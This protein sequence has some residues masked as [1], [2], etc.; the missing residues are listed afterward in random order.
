MNLTGILSILFALALT[1]ALPVHAIDTTIYPA[2]DD[3]GAGDPAGVT[4]PAE[5]SGKPDRSAAQADWLT[6]PMDPT[7]HSLLVPTAEWATCLA[8]TLPIFMI[9][10]AFVNVGRISADQFA[11]AWTRPPEWDD[12][13]VLANFVLHPIMGAEAYLTVRNRGYGPIGSFLFSSGVSI[14][15]EYLFEAWVE[16]PSGQD[17]LITSP[18]GSVQGEL[19]FQVRRQIA[20]WNPSVGRDALL[21]LVDPVEALH[22]YIGKVFFDYPKEATEEPMGSSLNVGPGQASLMITM[23]L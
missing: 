1:L 20:K 22:R 16:R 3:P 21:I 4:L 8:L 2:G 7:R 11:E 12:D 9:D 18:L 6:A 17:L 14:G 5:P 13:S 23:R 15:W 10:P 19:R